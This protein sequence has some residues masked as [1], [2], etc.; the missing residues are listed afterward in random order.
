M[1][2]FRD[3][4]DF[5]LWARLQPYPIG[6]IDLAG[7]RWIYDPYYLSVYCL[8]PLGNLQSIYSRQESAQ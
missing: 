4:L 6:G 2:R 1:H 5:H 8:D 7:N 3:G